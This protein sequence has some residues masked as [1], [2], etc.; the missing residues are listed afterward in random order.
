MRR[1]V[2]AIVIKDGKVL[3]ARRGYEGPLAKLWEFPGGKVEEG[4]SEAAALNREFLEEFGVPLEA[5]RR[6]G[7]TSFLH[8]GQ[9]RGLVAWLARLPAEDQLSLL[10]HV[11]LRWASAAEFTDIDLVDSDRG[12]LPFVL[13]LLD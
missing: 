13:P 5:Q 3:L 6:L 1:S 11:Q 10:E 12:L 4:E 2:A 7:E 8:K 9:D